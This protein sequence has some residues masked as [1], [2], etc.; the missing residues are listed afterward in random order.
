[1]FPSRLAFRA[2]QLFRGLNCFFQAERTS[3]E[4]AQAALNSGKAECP[5]SGKPPQTASEFAESLPAPLIARRLP[6][7]LRWLPK[8]AA[9]PDR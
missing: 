2:F 7:H 8:L 6:H 3:L 5:I 4:G 9:L 1:M